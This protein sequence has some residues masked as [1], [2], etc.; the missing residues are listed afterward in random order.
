MGKILSKKE[1]NIELII[2]LNI[3][4]VITQVW[5]WWTAWLHVRL[6]DIFCRAPLTFYWKPQVTSG[7]HWRVKVRAV[8]RYF[9]SPPPSLSSLRC[10][11]SL[12]SFA[13]I[14]ILIRPSYQLPRERA[15]SIVAFYF[16]IFISKEEWN[17]LKS[18]PSFL[19]IYRWIRFVQ[20]LTLNL[21]CLGAGWYFTF[22]EC[23]CVVCWGSLND[24]TFRTQK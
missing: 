1:R 17:L 3:L 4:K 7:A 19:Q 24:G 22:Y 6:L 8:R 11:L 12:F 5:F 16:F 13:L 15:K 14:F 18:N 10:C 9:L 20:T 23:F 21:T 2:A